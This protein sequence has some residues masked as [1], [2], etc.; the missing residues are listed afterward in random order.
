M[1]HLVLAVPAALFLVASAEV[2]QAVP[3]DAIPSYHVIRPGL[4]AA[5]QPSPQAIAELGRMGF[6]TV[7]NLR[8]D[9]ETGPEEKAAVE[10]QGLRYVNVPI[11][12]DTFSLESVKAVEAV[13][14]D[15]KAGPVLLH[16]ASSN[17]VGAVWAAVQVRRGMPLAQALEEG[18]AAGLKPTMEGPLLR[19]LGV[20]AAPAAASHPAPQGR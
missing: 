16:C 10:A 12:H 5:G 19:V 13:L 17:R 3:P 2:P 11:T 9:S 15:P 14:A 7:V 4:V 8:P 18:R 20:P 1:T 6:R